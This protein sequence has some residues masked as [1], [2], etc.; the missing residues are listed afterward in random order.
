MKNF[1]IMRIAN[2]EHGMFGTY[3]YEG[4]PF[5]VTLEPP[6]RNNQRNISCIPAGTYIA[7]LVESPK[8]G[9]VYEI[10]NV[11]G[12]THVLNHWGNKLD[13]TLGC[14]LVAEKFGILHGKPVVLTSKNSPGEGFNEFMK[15]AGGD[16][17]I[18]LMIRDCWIGDIRMESGGLS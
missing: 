4:V 8:Y 16:K 17:V 3:L 9:F 10:T 7:E 12:R 18:W 15:L 14:V 5:A 11:P 13:E 1:S 2:T 6:W